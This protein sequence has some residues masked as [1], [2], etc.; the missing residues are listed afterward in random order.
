MILSH[1]LYGGVDWNHSSYKLY[2]GRFKVTSYTEVWIEIFLAPAMIPAIS[3][4]SYTEVW[5]EISTTSA[6]IN[7]STN[8]TSY[9]EVWIE[10]FFMFGQGGDMFGHLL[11]GGVDWNKT[12]RMTSPFS[13]LVTSYTEVWIE[14]LYQRYRVYHMPRSPPIRR[15]GLKLDPIG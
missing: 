13:N 15:C 8:V 1:L 2:D 4:T 9:T 14:I 3:V 11:Y 6:S 12:E 7:W 5:I 10:I